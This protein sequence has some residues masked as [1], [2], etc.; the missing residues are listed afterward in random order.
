MVLLY[1]AFK[2][3]IMQQLQNTGGQMIHQAGPGRP[4]TLHE[5]VECCIQTMIGAQLVGEGVMV[6]DCFRALRQDAAPYFVLGDLPFKKDV[7]SWVEVW[8]I[9]L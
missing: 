2:S 6:T 9:G 5:S 7:V 3:Q 4:C 8:Q 1:E